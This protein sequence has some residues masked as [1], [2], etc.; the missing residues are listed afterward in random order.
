MLAVFGGASLQRWLSMWT[1]TGWWSSLVGRYGR[2]WCRDRHE[3]QHQCRAQLVVGE[4]VANR[5]D[6]VH[7]RRHHVVS[8][9]G[10]SVGHLPLIH[11]LPR[12]QLIVGDADLDPRVAQQRGH[13]VVPRDHPGV[14]GVEIRDGGM[15]AR[16]GERVPRPASH[17]GSSSA[18]GNS[19]RVI[20]SR[21]RSWGIR[22]LVVLDGR[23]PLRGRGR[24]RVP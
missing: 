11:L 13:V 5:V 17:R 16:I 10:A 2:W 23:V 8:W 18:M 19:G 12:R 14:R 22:D 15:I 4:R 9:S 1:A 6:R 3:Q 24:M 20:T 7:Q 21:L